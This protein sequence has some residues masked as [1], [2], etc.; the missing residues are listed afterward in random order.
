MSDL[1][2]IQ[3]LEANDPTKVE[4]DTSNSPDPFV[5]RMRGKAIHG[6][7]PFDVPFITQVTE[8]LYVGG[9][10][11]GLVLPREIVHMVSLYPWEAY[12]IQHRTRSTMFV[13]M[14]DS[15]D[16]DTTQVDAI[17]DW[18]NVCAEDGPT[19]V[20]CQAGLNRSNLIAA[21]ALVRS[22]VFSPQAA[23]DLLRERR[24]PAILCNHAFEEFVL[25][26]VKP[27]RVDLHG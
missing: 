5:R 18:V 8:T 10:E 21:T 1:S 24:S 25:G 22:G 13:T 9:C 17:A 4:V 15:F 12:R 20:H 7:T 16:Q 2:P 19:L 11:T 14:Y 6:N 26:R 3:Q 23:I 27:D